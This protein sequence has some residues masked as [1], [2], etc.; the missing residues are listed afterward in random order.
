VQKSVNVLTLNLR[1]SAL[2]VFN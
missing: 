1:Y 2:Y